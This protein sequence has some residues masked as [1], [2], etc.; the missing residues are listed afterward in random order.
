MRLASTL[1]LLA[2]LVAAPCLA[3]EAASDSSAVPAARTQLGDWVAICNAAPSAERQQCEADISLSVDAQPEPVARVA[4]YAEGK[5]QPVRL[6]AIVKA[7]LMLAPGV[8]IA[9][10]GGKTSFTL[11]FKSCLNSACLSDLDL[12][13]EQVETFRAS[14]ESARLTITNAGGEKLST[15][16]SPKGLKEALDMVT[17]PAPAK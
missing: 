3:E 17:G 2:I 15:Q 13:S 10:D 14:R 11:P 8:E 4:F 9:A 7:N 6:V 16:I 1:S 12:T 5:G